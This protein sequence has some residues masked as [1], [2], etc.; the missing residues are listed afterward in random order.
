MTDPITD[1]STAVRA[2]GAL[3]MP[4]GSLR[5]TP[6]READ[7]RALHQLADL[8]D[9]DDARTGRVGIPVSYGHRLV[10]LAVIGSF[11]AWETEWVRLTRTESVD[12]ANAWSA[13]Q[14]TQVQ[15]LIELVYLGGAMARPKSAAEI[16]ALAEATS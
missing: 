6:E 1:L 13:Q 2:E 8:M 5:L 15:R 3:P 11:E 16:R 10:W 7:N 14:E 4:V 12:A 9:E